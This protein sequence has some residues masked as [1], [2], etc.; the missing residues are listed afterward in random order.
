M[1]EPGQTIGKL[2]RQRTH[3]ET[4]HAGVAFAEAAEDD[5]EHP[6]R[7]RERRIKLNAAEERTK[8]PVDHRLGESRA[9]QCDDGGEILAAQQLARVA[10]QGARAQE[11]DTRFVRD[12]TDRCARG[13]PRLTRRAERVAHDV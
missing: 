6:P 9:S 7:R 4:R 13:A 2:A 1:H 8:K 5:V 10:A 3:A 12:R 11:R